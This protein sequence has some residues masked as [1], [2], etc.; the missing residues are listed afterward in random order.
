MATVLA[1]DDDDDRNDWQPKAVRGLPKHKEQE[2]MNQP[3]VPG[4]EED[5]S[6]GHYRNVGLKKMNS[7][8]CLILRRGRR[9][10][11]MN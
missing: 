7:E 6:E 1:D 8:Y 4:I 9:F 5:E 3:N 2:M 11:R 10:H